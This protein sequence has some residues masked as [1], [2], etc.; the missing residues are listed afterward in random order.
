MRRGIFIC[1]R[2]ELD[3]HPA[4]RLADEL[5]A[6]FGRERVFIDVDRL[7]L[8]NWR[9]QI[10]EA[11]E[12]AAVVLVV[13]GRGW[14]DEFERPRPAG[15]HVRYEIA[16]ALRRGILVTPVT[17]GTVDVPDPTRL[18][19]EIAG[20]VESQNYPVL[21]DAFW[22]FSVGRLADAI[23]TELEAPEPDAGSAGP[24]APQAA[25]EDGERPDEGEQRSPE[26]RATPRPRRQRSGT[27]PHPDEAH[28]RQI[29]RRLAR[30]RVVLWIG[31]E[32]NSGSPESFEDGH[33]PDADE[34]ADSLARTY[35]YPPGE[36]VDLLDVA[37]YC[38]SMEGRGSFEHE[39]ATLLE[40]NSA[41][42]NG[43]RRLVQLG[44]SAA[45][46][47]ARHAHHLILTTR[48]DDAIER[49]FDVEAEPYDLLV[50]LPHGENGGLFRHVPWG[51][52][53]GA[54]VADPLTYA[55]LPI[56]PLSDHVMRT[57]IVKLNGQPDGGGG[58]GNAPGGCMLTRTDADLYMAERQI[59][60][61]FPAAVLNTIMHAH[62]LFLGCSAREPTLR[63]LLARLSLQDRRNWAIDD[64]ADHVD[65]E[66]WRPHGAQALC[67]APAEYLGAVLQ[68][69]PD[70]RPRRPQASPLL[71]PEQRA[72]AEGAGVHQRLSGP[73]V[74]PPAEALRI[75]RAEV[76]VLMAHARE[77][78]PHICCGYAQ[79]ENE[80]VVAVVRGENTL[81][82]PYRFELDGRSLLGAHELDSQ[83]FEVAIYN[84]HPRSSAEPSRLS[85]ELAHYPDWTYLIVS[86][87]PDEG[88]RAWR[89]VDGRAT[90]RPLLVD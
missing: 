49:A 74:D 46:G 42:T 21:D 4:G 16:E 10:D 75:S 23:K 69:L 12:G 36:A 56:D 71:D 26:P 55:E 53:T 76:D 25:E 64:G 83:G 22:D 18:P 65:E 67:A 72:P 52:E 41:P 51:S 61:V 38:V 80:R 3:R 43:H 63:S 78:A 1:Y 60:Q 86:L 33:P 54:V 27:A 11:L 48:L 59:G 7:R 79:I 32:F 77:E 31:W 19:D 15:D 40:A 44:R 28:Y 68:H 35:D 24:T 73:D 34:L 5:S 66:F 45:G 39:L 89:I 13:I 9:R 87:V 85:R 47:G 30:T 62:Q 37:E 20:L 88:V 57:T 29:A 50:Y 17:L 81:R 2:R 58:P 84:S 82:S 8:G 14:I 70:E 6:R 90:E